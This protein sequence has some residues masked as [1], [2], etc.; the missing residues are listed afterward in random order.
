MNHRQN[1]ALSRRFFLKAAGISIALPAFESLAGSSQKKPPMRMVCICTGLGMHPGSFFPK[2]YGRGYELSPVLS[3][4]GG[5]RD[6]FTVFSHMD[7]PGIFTKHGAMSSILSGVTPGHAAPG[8]NVSMDQVAAQH[9]GYQTRFP[10]VHISLA[11][12]QGSSWSPSGIKVREEGDPSALFQRLF[13]DDSEAAKKARKLELDQQGSVLDLV[14]GQAKHFERNINAPD[15]AKLDE[16]LT[17]VREA[18]EKIQGMKRW[19]DVPKPKVQFAEGKHAHSSVDYEVLSPL[20]FDLLFLAIQSDTSRVF[21]AGFGMH[22]NVI[23]LEGVT[24]GYHG[25]SHHGNLEDKLKQLQIIETFYIA[26]M[27]RFMDKLKSA[28]T[29]QSHLLNETMVWFGSGLGDAASHSNRDL[30]LILAG[31]GFKHGEHLDCKRP[32]GTQT[33][34]NNLFT[35][36][37]QNFGVET[38]R[39]N[40]A[41]GNMN[42]LKA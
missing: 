35:T 14:R 3:P 32:A 33:P 37:L 28:R 39:F 30:P 24:E 26:Q 7:H 6:D 34:L 21:T 25:L 13:V 10:S 29:G 23:E 12:S 36:M 16:Y 18:E 19:E 1:S 41:T 2:A 15:R 42:Q 11:G 27:A 17:A 31:G 5:L 8:E 40:N 38:D 4:L 22:N 20:M 9:A